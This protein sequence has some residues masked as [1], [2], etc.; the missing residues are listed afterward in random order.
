MIA[1]PGGLKL[2]AALVILLIAAA[3]IGGLYLSGS[4]STERG[5]QFDNQRL[6]SLQQIANAVDNYY[7]DNNQLPADLGMLMAAKDQMV[8]LS[9]SLNDPQTKEPYEYSQLGGSRYELCAVFDLTSQTDSQG[10]PGTEPVAMPA[11]PVAKL[12]TVRSWEHAAGRVCF[13]LNATDR[14]GFIR[15]NLTNPCQAGQSCIALSDNK[16]TVCVPQGKECLAAGCDGACTLSESYPAQVTCSG[17]PG[18]QPGC[19]LMQD[20]KTGK[21]NCFG[22]ASGVCTDPPAGWKDYAPARG[23][24]G[25]PY[26]CYEDASG[27]A[28]A[29]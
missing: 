12:G 24:I 23:A 28:L 29:Q 3:V 13:Q 15:C 25:I 6:N 20:P 26:A 7:Y 9:G 16:G 11:G 21:V 14:G 17:R 27:C 5:R 10:G 2:F 4:P 1:K 18:A 19:R 22:C 8:Y